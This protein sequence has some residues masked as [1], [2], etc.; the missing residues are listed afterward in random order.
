MEYMNNLENLIRLH[1]KPSVGL[2]NLMMCKEITAYINRF[3]ERPYT[4][5]QVRK[6]LNYLEFRTYRRWQGKYHV[7]GYMIELLE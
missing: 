4:T 1:I 7:Q 3:T 2:N 5:A 6:M